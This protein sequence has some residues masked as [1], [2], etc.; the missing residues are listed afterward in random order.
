METRNRRRQRNLDLISNLPRHIIDCVL[1][2]LPLRDAVRTSILSR[3][4]RG[5]SATLPHL[6][7][8]YQF[9]LTIKETW[10]RLVNFH[11]ELERTISKFFV[12]HHGPLVKV[13]LY[14]PELS[15]RV[16]DT[17]QW[18]D[19][20]SRKNIKE[21]TLDYRYNRRHLLPRCFFSCLD[22]THLELRSTVFAP[23]PDFNGFRNLI[24]LKFR[25]VKLKAYK[26]ESLLH[27]SPLLQKLILV[28]CSGFHRIKVSA[29]NLESF[30]LQPPR[31][32]KT[33]CF[34]DVP[35]LA[36]VT[37]S[38]LDTEA[39]HFAKSSTLLEF[40]TSLPKL[41]RLSVNGNLLKLLARDTLPQE[42]PTT[43]EGLN[44]LKLNSLDFADFDQIS[45]AL[46]LI[47]NTPNLNQLEIQ[48]STTRLTNIPPRKLGYME[49]GAPFGCTLNRLQVVKI[50][51]LV[52]FKPELELVEFLLANSPFLEKIYINPENSLGQNKVASDMAIELIRS[53]R[54]SPGA[55]I[56]YPGVDIIYLTD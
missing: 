17:D 47:R 56:I 42:L 4:W 22:L 20:L 19:L 24:T 7:F 34:E 55:N 10:G 32:F 52:G 33:I 44:Y 9:Y 38:T 2:R 28:D 48:A 29:P 50:E 51:L 41:T 45:C 8:G 23:P 6:D 53:Y 27:G 5:Y 31:K 1:S 49:A 40:L 11:Y 13:T 54:S 26:L 39:G 46:C 14:I 43:V 3:K 25:R 18:I 12:L 30:Q 16:P 37:V 36:D 35:K 15:R 21:L